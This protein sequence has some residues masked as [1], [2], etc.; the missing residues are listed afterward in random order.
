MSHKVKNG[1]K[2]VY[3][4]TIIEYYITSSTSSTISMCDT[5]RPGDYPEASFD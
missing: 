1:I 4:I 3:Y 5:G 2:I